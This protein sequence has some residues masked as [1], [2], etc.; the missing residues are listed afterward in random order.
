MRSYQI[1]MCNGPLFKKI[2]VFALPLVASGCL[3][4]LFNAADII[5]V[6]RFSGS[7]ALAAVGSTSS[8]INL[9]VNLF[10]GISVGANVVLGRCIGANDYEGTSKAVHTAIFISIIGGFMMIFVGFFLSKP[11][12]VLMST[13]DNVIDLSVLYMRIYFA[14]MPFFMLYN[15]GAAI[16]RSVGDTK[17]PLYFLLISGIINVVFNLFFVICFKMSVSGV[18]IATVISECISSVLILMCLKRTEGPLHFELKEMRFHAHYALQMLEVGLPAGLQGIVFSI[19]NVLIQSSINSFGSL[20]MAGNTAASNIEGFVYTSMNAVYQT[21]LS[22]SSQNF[23]A[24][25]FDRIDKV[26]LE[27]LGLVT[28]IGLVLGQ[29]AYLLGRPLLSIYSSNSKVIEYGIE[30]LSVVGATYCICGMMDTLVGALRGVG[31]S[32]LPMI[33]SLTGVCVFRVIWI[34]T[35]FQ[36]LHTQFSLYVSYPISWIITVAAHGICFM[37]VRKKI[38]IKNS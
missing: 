19:S 3:Q 2:V 23:G 28:I 20:V 1:D 36:S 37:V 29:G 18:A 30:R 34:F 16:L 24:K 12:L 32:V 7:V 31:Y 22:F 17:R 21:S 14:G 5:V 9:L 8:L 6:G 35:V 27:C 13:P 10:I 11:L 33:V 38:R 4:L 25:K 15:F 26:L